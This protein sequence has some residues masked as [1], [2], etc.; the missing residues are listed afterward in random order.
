MIKSIKMQLLHILKSKSAV[1]VFFVLMYA[2]GSN[3][4]IN[5]HR[6]HDILYVSQMF[7]ITKVL[8]LSDWSNAGYY[9]MQYYPLLVVIPTA[10]IY[11]SDKKSGMDIYIT[12][13]VGKKDYF[14]GKMISV[15]L[16]TF[17]IFTIPFLT[18]LILS[19]ICFDVSSVGDPSRFQYFQTIIDDGKI[20][21][22]WL[23]V[24]NKFMYASMWI[25]VFG[26]VSAILAT[27]NFAITL[28]PVFKYRITTF[29]PIYFLLHIVNMIGKNININYTTYYHFILRMFGSAKRNYHVYA[30][31]LLMLLVASVILVCYVIRNRDIVND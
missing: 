6:N 17:I 7:D 2:V 31:F 28:L 19:C 8:T 15:F 1:L 26:L 30:Y 16:A 3:F 4:I 20:V 27:F 10:S 14:L 22:G 29:F 11:I 18:E 25:M 13:K 12:S 23:Y 5:M 24:K 21:F 9:I